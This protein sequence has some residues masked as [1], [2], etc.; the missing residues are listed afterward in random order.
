[1]FRTLTFLSLFIVLLVGVVQAQPSKPEKENEAPLIPLTA[2]EK[3]VDYRKVIAAQPDF[4]AD[5]IFSREGKLDG[6]GFMSRLTRIGSKYRE[7]TAEFAVIGDAGP[8]SPIPLD[9]VSKTYNDIELRDEPWPGGFEN[10]DPKLLA[11]AENTFSAL[12]KRTIDG[13]ECIKIQVKR[14]SSSMQISLYAAPDLKNLVIG[15]EYHVVIREFTS[16]KI[17]IL[18]RNVDFNPPASLVHIPTDYRPVDRIRWKKLENARV[19]YDG[20]DVKDSGV[21]RSPTGELFVWY[22]GA[23]VFGE[24][25]I[26]PGEGTAETTF[27]G[28]LVDSNRNP[29]MRSKE[30]EAFSETYYLGR[31]YV[32]W[33]KKRGGPL[34]VESDSLKFHSADGNNIWIEIILDAPKIV[35]PVKVQ[36]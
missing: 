14:R 30:P 32:N 18:L 29:I 33:G 9:R 23:Q 1:M 7:E 25:L 15:I 34:T 3:A 36:P 10:F 19:K 22:F 21:Y 27:F 17:A 20:Q 26:R 2:E 6:S 35:G 12:G 11:T 31:D 16:S 13:H 28:L 24:Y 4:T 8:M 5:R